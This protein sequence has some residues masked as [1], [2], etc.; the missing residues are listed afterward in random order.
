VLNKMMS[1][2]KGFM[3]EVRDMQSGSVG[4]GCVLGRKKSDKDK[5]IFKRDKRV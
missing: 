5:E 1:V 3:G 4:K 2:K